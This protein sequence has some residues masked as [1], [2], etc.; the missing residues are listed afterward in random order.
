[1]KLFT[2]ILSAALAVGALCAQTSDRLNVRFPGPVVVNGVTLP[3]GEEHTLAFA[4]R[5]E[6]RMP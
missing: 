2:V 4:L 5:A 3:A 1:M 6:L